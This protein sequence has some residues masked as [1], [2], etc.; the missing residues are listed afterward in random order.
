MNVKPLNFD[1]DCRGEPAGGTIQYGI[2]VRLAYRSKDHVYTGGQE[3]REQCTKISFGEFS[4]AT[5][6]FVAWK[7]RTATRLEKELKCIM[8]GDKGISEQLFY[9]SHWADRTANDQADDVVPGTFDEVPSKKQLRY[10]FFV[11]DD[12]HCYLQNGKQKKGDEE[13]PVYIQMANFYIVKYLNVYQFDGGAHS[14]FHKMLCRKLHDPNGSGT[15]YLSC[16]DVIRQPL[17]VGKKY[18]DIE[19]LI[20]LTAIKATTDV[21]CL[22]QSYHS[23]LDAAQMT[24]DHLACIMM[25]YDAPDAQ[26]AITRF[27]RQG[28]SEIFVAGNCAFGNGELM[29]HEEAGVAIVPR[30]FEEAIMPLPRSEYPRHI[31]IPFPH[32]RYTIGINAWTHIMPKFFANNDIAAK[33]TF[34][35]AVLGMHADKVWGGQTGFG[36]GFPFAWIYSTEPN[37]AS[38]LAPLKTCRT[39]YSHPISSFLAFMCRARQRRATSPMACLACSIALCGLAT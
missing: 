16:E 14:P 28:E 7:V 36:H 27:G 4:V 25:A 6:N 32:V 12:C 10:D 9:Q 19:V 2:E 13:E 31:L 37:T 23:C 3:V 1:E 5:G 20:D 18:F 15:A 34:T 29:T 8:V 24:V 39:F 22:F 11:I 30:F 35:M 38:C 17:L 21:R 26:L 33:A